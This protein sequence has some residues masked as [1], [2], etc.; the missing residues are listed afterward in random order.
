MNYQ[1]D[2]IIIGDSKEGN[3][4]LKKVAATKPNIKIAF[5][6]R[7]FKNKTSREFI[8]VE[9]IQD[10]VILTDYKNR[11][12][13]CYLKTGIRLYCT[14][15]I[16]AV[17]VKYAP[18]EIGKKVVP[19]V[20]NTLAN[21][22]KTSKESQAIVIAKN[23]ED[24]KFA[25]NVAKKYKHVYVC[26]ET[27]K[28]DCSIKIMKKLETL[29]NIVLLFNASI[30]S[31][32]AS[33][34]KLE[35]VTLDNY[36]SIT[37]TAIFVKTPALADTACIPKNLIEQDKEGYLKVNE[38]A[39]STL[40]PKCYAIGNCVQKSSKKMRQNLITELENFCFNT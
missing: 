40:V 22:P 20:F 26:V 31:F 17:G 27:S 11:L 16:F 33:G 35:I 34:N 37:C 15:L 12:F 6:S 9:Y 32:S 25:I 30:K 1:F 10:E 36:S 21:I 5:I 7:E 8:N 28:I 19:N 24:I 14:H 3:Q 39:E 23:E 4:L 29:N 13:G 18:Y 2:I 38:R